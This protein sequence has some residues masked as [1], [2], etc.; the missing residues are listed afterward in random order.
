[1]PCLATQK[2]ARQIHGGHVLSRGSQPSIKYNLH[3]IHRQSAQSNHWQ[4]DDIK[5]REGLERE[6][7]KEYLDFVLSL[8]QTRALKFTKPQY[9][10]F[11]RIAC[12]IVNDLRK[13]GK[14]FNT[15]E[16]IEMRNKL[17]IKLGIYHLRHSRYDQDKRR[18]EKSDS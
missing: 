16:R 6:Y 17:N 7:G 13:Q 8:K 5:M 14:T 15:K 1:M 12:D 9:L 11:Y 18:N 3:N 2:H 10:A 4:A